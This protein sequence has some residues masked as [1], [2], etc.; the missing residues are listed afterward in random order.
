MLV[1]SNK[2][3]SIANGFTCTVFA[4]SP[5]VIVYLNLHAIIEM[6]FLL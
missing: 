1:I 6:F 2:I 3:L 5:S 4:I